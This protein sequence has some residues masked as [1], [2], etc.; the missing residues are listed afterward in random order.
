MMHDFCSHHLAITKTERSLKIEQDFAVAEPCKSA[1]TLWNVSC[2]FSRIVAGQ[3]A[4]N[5]S[6]CNTLQLP[7]SLRDKLHEKYNLILLSETTLATC[8]ATI[9]AV[10][11]YVTQWNVSCNLS[12]PQ[13]RQNIAR[14]VARNISQWNSALNAKS[15]RPKNPSN[16]SGQRRKW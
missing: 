14:Q 12:P 8:L 6:Q 7:K 4:W 16:H 9:L 15:K 5:I 11:G 13:C 3:V 10:A 1:V 2:N